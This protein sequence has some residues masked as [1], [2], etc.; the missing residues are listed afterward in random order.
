MGCYKLENYDLRS[1]PRKN[2]RP[3]LKNNYNKMGW[4]HGSSTGH[5]TL[6]SNPGTINKDRERKKKRDIRPMI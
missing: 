2:T 1:V 4:G 5:N 3:Y 6:S